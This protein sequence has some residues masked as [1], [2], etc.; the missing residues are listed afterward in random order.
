[1][2]SL[3]LGT[4][5]L[6]GKECSELV[7][8]A[9]EIGYRHIDTAELYDN[10]NDVALGIASFPREQLFL[11]SKVP[12]QYLAPD[13]II[14]ICDKAL[15]ELRTDYLDLLLVHWPSDTM[16][17]KA[18]MDT[19]ADLVDNGKVR[20]I[21]VSNFSSQL[22]LKAIEL[23]RIPIANIQV[24]CHLHL[25][26]KPL[27]AICREKGVSLTAYA[28]LGRA[29]IF[30]TDTI[31]D[32]SAQHSSTPAQIALS[33]LLHHGIVVIPKS[34][35]ADRLLENFKASEIQLSAE[36]VERLD[37]LG[38]NERFVGTDWVDNSLCFDECASD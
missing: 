13:K 19:F 22:L 24:E 31:R 1:M 36:D 17:L 28:P 5:R 18:V 4:W 26:Q 14:S 16:N 34:A 12:Y 8:T 23:S 25:Q 11:T 32:I 38:K 29:R 9:I 33:W 10:Q 15:K 6:K 35:D 7:R 27:R 20:S 30:D 37:K 2:S 21:G 3:G